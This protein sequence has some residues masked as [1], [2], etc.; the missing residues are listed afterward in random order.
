[1]FKEKRKKLQSLDFGQLIEVSEVL[2]HESVEAFPVFECIKVFAKLTAG[3]QITYARHPHDLGT[4]YIDSA[5]IATR[6][7]DKTRS[8][9]V[10]TALNEFSIV[11]KEIWPFAPGSSTW[12]QLEILHP[13]IRSRGPINSPTIVI[14]KACRLSSAKTAPPVST[15]PLLER[16]F[17]S[18]KKSCPDSAGEFEIICQPSFFL[19]N[20]AG[21]GVMTECKKSI[22]Q[23]CMSV[24]EAADL[25][26]H[27]LVE[28][29]CHE[30]PKI[31]PG[32][33]V[34]VGSD[35]YHI[36]ATSYLKKDD[37]ESNPSRLPLP[38][39]GWIK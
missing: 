23:D 16:M 21:S 33:F 29:N 15:S 1:M 9:V 2:C 31:S 39:A 10:L 3:H 22:A 28:K 14:R 12:L 6:M 8:E 13:S 19:K 11:T 35:T 26:C 18:F 27:S 7:K 37:E 30:L 34:N 36:V 4:D 17:E 24:S 25:I 5:A 38:I 20:I 32:F